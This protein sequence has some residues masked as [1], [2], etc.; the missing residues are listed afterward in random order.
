SKTSPV[1]LGENINRPVLTPTITKNTICD[2]DNDGGNPY[3][4]KISLKV[5]F[6]EDEVTDFSNYSFTWYEGAST[7]GT[8]ITSATSATLS[9]VKHGQ[10]TVVVSRDDL[11]CTTEKTYTI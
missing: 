10:Y 6:D 5:T 8:L 11:G 3:D 1:S 9:N 7:S 2:P 4:G